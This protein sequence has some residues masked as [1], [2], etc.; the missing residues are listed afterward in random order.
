MECY[1]DYKKTKLLDLRI[2][3]EDFPLYTDLGA[4]HFAVKWIVHHNFNAKNV[5]SNC[6]NVVLHT[7]GKVGDSL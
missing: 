6:I 4:I 7:G 3:L 2:L 1:L 5:Y